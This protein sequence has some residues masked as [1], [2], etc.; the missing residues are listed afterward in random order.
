MTDKK[1]NNIIGLD[2]FDTVSASNKGSV[3]HFC[4]PGTDEE[5]FNGDTPLT[6]HVLGIESDAYTAHVAKQERADKNEDKKSRN[7]PLRDVKRDVALY[8][9]IV[10]GWTG[11]PNP[12]KTGMLKFSKAA[13]EEVLMSHAD[14]RHQLRNFLLNRKNFING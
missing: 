2:I 4:K 13:L 6:V 8:C 7:D 1:D 14:L 9:A 10:T 3:L 12:E 5:F 11:F